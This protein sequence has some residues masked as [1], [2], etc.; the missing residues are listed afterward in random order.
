MLIT[1]ISVLCLLGLEI[2]QSNEGNCIST[3]DSL[4]M[5]AVR[6]QRDW[7]KEWKEF[8]GRHQR[9]Q[10]LI[11][12]LRGFKLLLVLSAVRWWVWI[13]ALPSLL[14]SFVVV[15]VFIFLVWKL[16]LSFFNRTNYTSKNKVKLVEY[17]TSMLLILYV[18][19]FK[20]NSN[21]YT[22]RKIPIVDKHLSPKI[23]SPNLTIDAKILPIIFSSKRT[24]KFLSMLKPHT[25]GV[26]LTV[27]YHNRVFQKLC[28]FSV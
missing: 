3:G 2:R 15:R 21:R 17:K 12:S 11:S 1:N 7:G 24:I 5:W 14:W 6:F 8:Q 9:Q 23:S 26:V 27:I 16:K 22:Y 28:M 13:L 25:V 4:T 10:G 18:E 19:L 20:N